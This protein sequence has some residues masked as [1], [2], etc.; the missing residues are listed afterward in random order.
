MIELD[1]VHKIICQ[2]NTVYCQKSALRLR[3]T[4]HG[5]NMSGQTMTLELHVAPWILQFWSVHKFFWLPQMFVN[6]LCWFSGKANVLCTWPETLHFVFTPHIPCFGTELWLKLS[7][8]PGICRATIGQSYR[9]TLSGSILIW[10]PLCK[11]NKHTPSYVAFFTPFLWPQSIITGKIWPTLI[12]S[13][14]SAIEAWGKMV[15]LLG[16]FLCQQMLIR[17]FLCF[18]YKQN[19]LFKFR[20]L[21]CKIRSFPNS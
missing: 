2:G 16:N 6:S 11:T 12:F 14:E 9:Y 19:C 1:A 4:F 5:L 21:S 10:G 7:L 8:I 13:V 17:L 20:R 15:I 18:I 3:C